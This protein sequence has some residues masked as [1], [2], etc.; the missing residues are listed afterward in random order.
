MAE[1]QH[2]ERKKRVRVALPDPTKLGME[3]LLMFVDRW[4]DNRIP[5]N[6]WGIFGGLGLKH[7]M[8]LGGLMANYPRAGEPEGEHPVVPLQKPIPFSRR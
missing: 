4:T 8:D 6:G 7:Q 2:A 3:R 1:Q 5:W